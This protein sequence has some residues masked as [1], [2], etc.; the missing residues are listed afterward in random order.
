MR[1]DIGIATKKGREQYPPDGIYKGGL[2]DPEG[3]EVCTCIESC[4]EGDAPDCHGECGC[5]ACAQQWQD[6]LSIE[7]W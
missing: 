2:Q 6:W 5:A 7:K 4:N 1:L 3:W